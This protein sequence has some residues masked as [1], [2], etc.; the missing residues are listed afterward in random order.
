MTYKVYSISITDKELQKK[1]NKIAAD[2]TK[3]LSKTIEKV[4]KHASF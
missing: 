3:N 1:L 2:E 4:L